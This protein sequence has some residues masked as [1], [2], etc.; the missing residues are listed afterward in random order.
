MIPSVI[1][2]RVPVH[3]IQPIAIES[4]LPRGGNPKQK[5]GKGTLRVALTQQGVV[6]GT[7]EPHPGF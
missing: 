3:T 7:I 4:E 2:H 1:Q 5:L 6:G